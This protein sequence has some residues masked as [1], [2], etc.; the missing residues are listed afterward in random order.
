MTYALHPD[1]QPNHDWR[2]SAGEDEVRGVI[3]EFSFQDPVAVGLMF[4]NALEDPSENYDVLSRLSTPES[5][6]AFGD[7]TEAA[8]LFKAIS[9]S[10][11]SMRAERALGDEDIAYFRILSGQD[12]EGSYQLLEDQIIAGAAIV[13]LAWRVEFGEWRVHGIGDYLRPEEVPH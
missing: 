12:G 7:F 13:T 6:T 4:C 1:D 2:R 8:H 10:K 3:P 9:G 5:A 11:Y